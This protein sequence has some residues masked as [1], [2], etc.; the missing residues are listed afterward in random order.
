VKEKILALPGFPGPDI[1]KPHPERYRLGPISGSG[2]GMFAVGDVQP[3]EWL[4]ADRPLL[5]MPQAIPTKATDPTLPSRL[6]KKV[7]MEHMGHTNR[8]LF[9]SLHNCKSKEQGDLM[10]IV[11]TNAINIGALPGHNAHYAAVL[12]DFSRINHRF[13]LLSFFVLYS[14][15]CFLTCFYFF[16]FIFHFPFSRVNS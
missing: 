4:G 9:L 11:N 10:G 16:L 13:D 8:D 2:I 6:V 15:R 12:R 1:T 14:L 7:V 5:V 3:G